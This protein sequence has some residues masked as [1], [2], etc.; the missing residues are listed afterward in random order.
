MVLQHATV[1]VT[2]SVQ[3][4]RQ[5]RILKVVLINIYCNNDL[6]ISMLFQNILKHIQYAFTAI[7]LMYLF[8]QS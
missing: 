3:R 7:M 1:L 6:C 5:L 4:G 2:L 8:C